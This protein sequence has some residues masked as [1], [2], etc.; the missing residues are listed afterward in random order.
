[1]SNFEQMLKVTDEP[2]RE[3]VCCVMDT[4][5]LVYRWIE[6]RHGVVHSSFDINRAVEM[7]IEQKTNIEFWQKNREKMT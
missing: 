5:D 4:Y 7:I 6:S 2:L 3:S 1:M